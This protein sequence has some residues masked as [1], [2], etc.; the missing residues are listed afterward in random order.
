MLVPRELVKVIPFTA[1]PIGLIHYMDMVYTPA[2][3]DRLIIL[4]LKKK[5]RINNKIIVTINY[6]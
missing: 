5:K 3:P 4:H 2:D 6:N 1:P